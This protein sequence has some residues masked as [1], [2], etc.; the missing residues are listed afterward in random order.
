[1]QTMYHVPSHFVPCINHKEH[2]IYTHSEH[3]GFSTS[4]S[5]RSWGREG[6]KYYKC[7]Q[8][9]LLTSSD[10]R[11]GFK[12]CSS[13]VLVYW[14]VSPRLLV[15]NFSRPFSIC[16]DLVLCIFLLYIYP[17]SF[18]CWWF[19]LLLTF[20]HVAHPSLYWPSSSSYL[21]TSALWS[22]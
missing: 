7:S 21:I 10:I 20:L 17:F 16:V 19:P 11:D 15:H 12:I 6:G 2:K 1:M 3:L 4:P 9:K 8:G 14:L 13:G 18:S 22:T 5:P